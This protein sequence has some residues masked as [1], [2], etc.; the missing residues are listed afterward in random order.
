[1]MELYLKYKKYTPIKRKHARNDYLNSI[2]TQLS[3]EGNEYIK[4]FF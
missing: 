1:M 2:P 3:G 4:P